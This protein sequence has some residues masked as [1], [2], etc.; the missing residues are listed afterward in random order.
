M[1]QIDIEIE[2]DHLL[3]LTDDNVEELFDDDVCVRV[4]QIIFQFDA[5]LFEN[6]TNFHVVWIDFERALIV[7]ACQPI[8]HNRVQPL[9]QAFNVRR[10]ENTFARILHMCIDAFLYQIGECVARKAIQQIHVVQ[11]LIGFVE[12]AD[13]L[14]APAA[15][16]LFVTATAL[17]FVHHFVV[18][19]K[20]GAVETQLSISISFSIYA[21]T[22]R[23]LDGCLRIL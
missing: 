5:K 11:I 2:F 8:Q 18:W 22:H 19:V 12:S 6:F 21:F 16:G 20:N 3:I 1:S 4:I 14:L 9:Q 23:Y 15:V 7:D 10:I 13:E 17:H